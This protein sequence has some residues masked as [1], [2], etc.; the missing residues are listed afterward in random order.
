[1]AAALGAAA[2]LLTG[3]C[4]SA[5]EV[6]PAP[7]ADDPACRSVPWPAEVSGR[8]RI[9]TTTTSFSDAAWG[10]PAIIARCGFEEVPPTTETCV[11]VDGVDWVVRQLSNGSAAT[12]FGTDPAIEVLVPQSYGAAPLQLPA[13]TA[14]ARSLP[15]TD[16]HCT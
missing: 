6:Q 3:A 1:M 12:T 8:S 14:A 7:H 2:V 15:Q 9:E 10:D 11:S 5:V 4:S 16:H 13:F